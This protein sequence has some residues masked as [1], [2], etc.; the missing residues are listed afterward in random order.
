MPLA[1]HTSTPRRLRSASA[2]PQLPFSWQFA[3]SG[4]LWGQNPSICDC[5]DSTTTTHSCSRGGWRMEDYATFLDVYAP[6]LFFNLPW[7]GKHQHVRVMFERQWT[8]LRQ[9]I[10]CCIRPA[11]GDLGS[12]V[13]RYRQ[14]ISDYADAAYEVCSSSCIMLCF[15]V[16]LQV[17]SAASCTNL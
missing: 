3:F 13:A 4:V 15:D 16:S 9:A 8:A 1:S 2:R 7:L 10:L 6:Y 11:D 14:F 17:L 12:Q 5:T